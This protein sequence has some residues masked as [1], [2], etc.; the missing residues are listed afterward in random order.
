MTTHS[1]G[2]LP[3]FPRTQRNRIEIYTGRFLNYATPAMDEDAARAQ[4]GIP[5][6][7]PH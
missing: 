4:G 3:L 2:Q 6:F 7:D 1:E 5:V